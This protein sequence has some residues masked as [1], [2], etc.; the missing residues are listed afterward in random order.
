MVRQQRVA[1]PG[2]QGGG[3]AVGVAARG[4]QRAGQEGFDQV[5]NG[6]LLTVPDQ[7]KSFSRR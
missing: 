1:D 3:G 5:G 7:S 2:D 4:L 6:C